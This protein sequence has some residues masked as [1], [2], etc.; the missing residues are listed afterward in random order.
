MTIDDAH[1]RIDNVERNSPISNEDLA[2]WLEF[3]VPLVMAELAILPDPERTARINAWRADAVPGLG[4]ADALM[5]RAKPGRA[6][7]SATATAKGVAA[8]AALLG[9]VEV[10]GLTFVWPGARP[11]KAEPTPPP[12]RRP[13]ETVHL[14]ALMSEEAR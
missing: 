12:Y 8:A 10:L 13:V 2:L 3:S 9:E 11:P 6:E 7:I 1:T 14:S 4:A 5:F